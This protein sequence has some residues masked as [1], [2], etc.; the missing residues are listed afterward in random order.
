MEVKSV[1][2]NN[3]TNNKSKNDIV[4]LQNKWLI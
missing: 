2:H 1:S 3:A 4:E